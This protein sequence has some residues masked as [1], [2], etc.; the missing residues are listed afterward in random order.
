MLLKKSR[1]L[2][3]PASGQKIDL[4][5]GPMRRSRASVE[6]KATHENLAM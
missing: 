5:D 3:H 1:Q 6:D 2:V 4:S